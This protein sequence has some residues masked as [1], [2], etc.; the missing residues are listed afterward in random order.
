MFF[1]FDTTAF[2][3]HEKSD[4]SRAWEPNSG[5]HTSVG[6]K[7]SPFVME[8]IKIKKLSTLTRKNA[9][10][11]VH[12]LKLLLAMVSPSKVRKVTPVSSIRQ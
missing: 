2:A 3:G 6:S 5:K 7:V 11:N 1:I 12:Q 4:T 9:C 8:Y 10:T